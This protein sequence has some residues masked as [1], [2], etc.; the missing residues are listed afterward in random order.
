M[1]SVKLVGCKV[2][3]YF[4]RKMQFEENK[5]NIV[6]DSIADTLLADTTDQGMPYFIEVEGTKAEAKAKPKAKAKAPARKKASNKPKQPEPV[7]D[8]EDDVP[9][10]GN[11]ADDLGDDDGSTEGAVS[12]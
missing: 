12:L 8:D 4:P 3:T 6:E 9:S 2:Y 7:I 5:V 10:F 1:R 11:D